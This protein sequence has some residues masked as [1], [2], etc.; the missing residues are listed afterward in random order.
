MNDILAKVR[1]A[2]ALAPKPEQRHIEK[3]DR[4]DQTYAPDAKKAREVVRTLNAHSLPLICEKIAVVTGDLAAKHKLQ[5]VFD[6]F[7]RANYAYMR[8]ELK[9]D[10]RLIEWMG[11]VNGVMP[12]LP[13]GAPGHKVNILNAWN[14]MVTAVNNATKVGVQKRH[15]EQPISLISDLE[16]TQLILPEN[17]FW[18]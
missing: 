13:P 16:S 14:A 12:T 1:Q 10:N 8:E 3:Q 11:G 15:R 6:S 18:N 2:A 17:G 7:C 9:S 5:E 4:T